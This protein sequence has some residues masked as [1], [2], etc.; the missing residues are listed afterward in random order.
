MANGDREGFMEMF[1]LGDTLL[2]KF[3]NSPVLVHSK[4]TALR[5]MW[6][7]AKFYQ[8]GAASLGLTGMLR[9][10]KEL[11]QVLDPRF[12]FSNWD[13]L[14]E[15]LESLA[16]RHFLPTF[17]GDLL[18]GEVRIEEHRPMARTLHAFVAWQKSLQIF[19][20]GVGVVVLFGI[21]CLF[22]SSDLK[23]RSRQRAGEI[24]T[25]RVVVGS[26]ILPLGIFLGVYFLKVSWH[27]KPDPG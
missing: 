24:S 6:D 21:Y 18:E 26:S 25:F 2:L 11:E 19:W 22:Q 27:A 7:E 5:S 20:L 13:R 17:A 12:G 15:P 10:L 16:S 4:D 3:V 23:Y 1:K 9:Q 14:E 8:A